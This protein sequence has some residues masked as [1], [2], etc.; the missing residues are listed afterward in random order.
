M[1]EGA[2]DEEGRGDVEGKPDEEGTWDESGTPTSASPAVA[3]LAASD[4]APQ[5]RPMVTPEALRKA[6]VMA[7]ILNRP[8]RGVRRW[9][10][11]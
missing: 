5:T 7:E 6:V 4:A 10:P 1:E 11:K 8:T 9:Q 3:A 2:A